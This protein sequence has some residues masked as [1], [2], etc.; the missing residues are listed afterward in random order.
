MINIIKKILSEPLLHFLLIGA[1]LFVIFDLKNG[2]DSE[3]PNRVFISAGEVEQL[4]QKFS[5]TWMREPSEEEMDSLVKN[6]IRDEI[7][8]REAVALGLDKNDP[9]I[10]R[11]MRQ[12]LEFIFEDITALADPSDETL[13]QY[14]NEHKDKF[15]KKPQLSFEQIYLS[16]DKRNDIQTD[17]Q[18]ILE[19]L[20]AGENPEAFGDPLMIES[21]Y[22]LLSQ[23]EIKR[24][25]GENFS[26]NILILPVGSWSGPMSSGYG[27]HLVRVTEKKQGR[28]PELSEIREKVKSEW[29]LDARKE[30]KDETFKKLLENY[31]VVVEA[32]K[33]PSQSTEA[34]SEQGSK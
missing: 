23:E 18:N 9:L 27:E 19:K 20:D 32:P 25:F 4:S 33:K 3:D 26:L 12:K 17:A 6:L 34:I 31:E 10:Q 24:R 8:Y 28:L 13:T 15:S 5:R 14:M 2:S 21:S 22:R 29:L 11:R 16:Y 1:V 7:Y 30:L